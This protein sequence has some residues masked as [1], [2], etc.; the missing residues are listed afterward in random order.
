MMNQ[1]LNNMN[2]SQTTV[3]N[4][5]NLFVAFS[6]SSLSSVIF[7]AVGASLLF[8]KPIVSILLK[9]IGSNA[10]DSFSFCKILFRTEL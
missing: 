8:N 7:F 3:S 2:Y 4:L 10:F 6:I 5:I 9:H 1:K